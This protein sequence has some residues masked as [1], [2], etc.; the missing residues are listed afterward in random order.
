MS[1]HKIPM[2]AVLIVASVLVAGADGWQRYANAR[3]GYAIDIPPG[4][5]EVAEADDSDGGTSRP[6]DGSAELAVW[7]AWLVDTGFSAEIAE[8]MRGDE[9]D[10]WALSYRRETVF[11]ASW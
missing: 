2:A 1:L 5:S 7:G 4:F 8:R 3:F 10:G 11:G 9:A 6:A